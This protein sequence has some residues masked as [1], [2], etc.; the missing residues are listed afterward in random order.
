MLFPYT[1]TLC[2]IFQSPLCDLAV[3]LQHVDLIIKTIEDVRQNID[4]KF[5]EL[6]K[7]AQNLLSTVNEEMKIPRIASVTPRA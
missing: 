4:S 5:A 3:A 1:L 2:K 7:N 6:F